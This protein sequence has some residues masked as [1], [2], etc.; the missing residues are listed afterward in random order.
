M[1]MPW[2][3]RPSLGLRGRSGLGQ[4]PP[5]SKTRQ[6]ALLALPFG[7]LP[8][9]PR[10]AARWLC[11][12]PLPPP[13]RGDSGSP[14]RCAPPLGARPRPRAPRPASPRWP[15]TARS[16]DGPVGF[17]RELSRRRWPAVTTAT[18]AALVAAPA[19]FTAVADACHSPARMS[20]IAK[21]YRHPPHQQKRLLE[22]N[23]RIGLL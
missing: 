14:A 9:S 22:I 17:P 13:L 6:R 7:G 8:G 19:A 20:Q 4:Q 23:S 10:R 18:A 3:S 21:G 15:A 11:P 5:N 12:Q 1:Q 2:S 16:H